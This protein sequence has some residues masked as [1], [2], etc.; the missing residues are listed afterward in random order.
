MLLTSISL[1]LYTIRRIIS[2]Q[3]QRMSEI[4]RGEG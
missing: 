4:A 2:L 3:V 1:A